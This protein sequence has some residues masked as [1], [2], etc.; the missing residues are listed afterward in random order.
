MSIT[1]ENLDGLK[2]K[3]TITL[4]TDKI[5]P[6]YSE[7]LH[8]YAKTAKMP[9]FRPGK[10][11]LT[12]LEQKVGKNLRLEILSKLMESEFMAAIDEKK[13]R[14]AGQP[15]VKP[16]EVVEK[17][18]PFEYTVTFEVYPDIELKTLDDVKLV[19]P[20]SSVTEDDIK[21][22]E[23]DIQKQ[24]AKWK[25]IE[26]AAKS[27]DRVIIDFEGFVDEKPFEGNQA[28]E[29]SLELG[30]N[31]FIPGFEDQLIGCVAGDKKDIQVTFPKDY[32]AK[33]LA[34]KP[35][36][37]KITIHRVETAELPELNDEFAKTLKIEGGLE[38]LQETIASTL[39]TNLKN[40][41]WELKKTRVLKALLEQNSILAPE[42]LVD[43]E[44]K[45]LQ[46]VTKSRFKQM[47]GKEWPKDQPMAREP[48]VEQATRQVK[49]GLL[50]AH[51][52]KKY[53]LTVSEAMLNERLDEFAKGQ[54]EPEKIR[55]YYK[56]DQRLLSQVKAVILEDAAIEKL[57]EAMN[58]EEKE[59]IYQDI[60]SLSE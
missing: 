51:V 14:I 30:S 2:R 13:L 32:R 43:M 25:T 31:Q 8:E 5:E 60:M 49:L 26:T 57:A 7:R 54:A 20:I 41:L 6:K 35:A 9:G 29:F 1:V 50:L 48:Y 24:H 40:K 12:V 45:H 53:D 55:S 22:T 47:H 58:I 37:F 46:E 52:I 59:M 23:K 4:P 10:V 19:V 28:K 17:D 36:T 42:S 34:G 44:I 27:G 15:I 11:P 33:D 39:K 56:Q 3:M 16:G 38:K 18:K 21:K